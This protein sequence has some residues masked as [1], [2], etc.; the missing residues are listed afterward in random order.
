MSSTERNNNPW[1]RAGKVLFVF[2]FLFAQVI[3][4]ALVSIPAFETRE[5]QYHCKGDGETIYESS[6]FGVATDLRERL[7]EICEAKLA[8][9]GV[10]ISDEAKSFLREFGIESEFDRLVD[11]RRVPKHSMSVQATYFAGT[12]IAV[13]FIF[14][15]F[16]RLLRYIFTGRRLI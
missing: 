5:A 16:A 13:L 11:S 6:I 1:Y 7:V 9:Q 3:L 12:F 2:V 10:E 8:A 15:V 4:L 14:F